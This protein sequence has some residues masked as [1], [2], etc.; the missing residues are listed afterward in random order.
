MLRCESTT[1]SVERSRQSLVSAGLIPPT[2]SLRTTPWR[3]F[4]A[5]AADVVA[6][7]PQPLMVLPSTGGI[8]PLAF[9]ERSTKRGGGGP[10]S[11]QR[12]QCRWPRLGG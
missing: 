12:L 4:M 8:E 2:G 6:L 10:L 1:A 7:L 3:W 11:L 5:G 9:I